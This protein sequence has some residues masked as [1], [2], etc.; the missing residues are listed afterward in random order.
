MGAASNNIEMLR[1]AL[2]AARMPFCAAGDIPI[3][4]DIPIKLL[5]R[6]SEQGDHTSMNS[7]TFPLS[8]ADDINPLLEACKQASF[9]RGSEEVL[10]PSYR[11]ALVLHADSFAIAPATAVDPYGLGMLAKIRQSL[12]S[13]AP[14]ATNRGEDEVEYEDDYEEERPPQGRRIVAHLDKMNVY[15]VGD[16]FKG[17]V[18]TPRSNQMLGTLVINLPVAHEG[19]H[20]VVH[21]PYPSGGA[22]GGDSGVAQS[23]LDGGPGQRDSYTTTWGSEDVLSWVAFFSD[24]PHEVLPVKR[25]NR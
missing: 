1:S 8:K 22:S 4:Q 24:C 6:V 17:H 19:G 15:G 14:G 20:L 3:S 9:G 21:A 25:G 13:D 12:L 10:D 18:D 5:F 2:R 16:F 23:P 11:R 7:V